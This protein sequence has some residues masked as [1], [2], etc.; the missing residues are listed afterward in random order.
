[1]ASNCCSA[2]WFRLSSRASHMS[3]WTPATTGVAQGREGKDWV[4]QTL[5]WTA[6]IVKHRP[7]SKQVWILG[8]I[9]NDQIDWSKY[10]PPPGFRVLP[11]RWVV[12]GTQPQYLQSALDV[13]ACPSHD[14]TRWAT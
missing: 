12:E 9:P 10:Y 3:G 13:Q 4:E 2:I 1:M 6:E 5:G 14:R 11:R 7:R 8:D